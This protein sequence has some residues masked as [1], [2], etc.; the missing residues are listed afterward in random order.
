ME[1]KYD[2]SCLCDTDGSR[3]ESMGLSSIELSPKCIANQNTLDGLCDS[4]VHQSC[5]ADCSEGTEEAYIR[6]Q[7]R[8]VAS[9]HK[10]KVKSENLRVCFAAMTEELLD[11]DDQWKKIEEMMESYEKLRDEIGND[12][13]QCKK[14]LH[15]LY[16]KEVKSLPT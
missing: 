7:R 2:N 11:L 4:S 13:Q 14:D 15:S 8:L 12:I 10:K 5:L 1:K 6:Q 9:K 3:L 16:E